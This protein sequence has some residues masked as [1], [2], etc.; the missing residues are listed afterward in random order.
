MTW[1]GLNVG[2]IG[3]GALVVLGVLS[4][5]RGWLVP[6]SVVRDL[7]ADRDSRIGELAGERDDWKRT[8]TVLTDT[9]RIQA[10]QID[11][12]TESARVQE[13][14]MRALPQPPTNG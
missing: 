7:R 14:M 10:A 5:M 9:T 1:N 11:E 8:C 12:L 2:D 4:L 6:R 3:A 13:A